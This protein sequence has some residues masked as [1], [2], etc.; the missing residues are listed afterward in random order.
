MLSGYGYR[1]HSVDVE[2]RSNG[3]EVSV[4]GRHVPPGPD[5]TVV[6]VRPAERGCGS[7]DTAG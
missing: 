7:G 6:A 4:D 3:F 1:G 2:I 5:G